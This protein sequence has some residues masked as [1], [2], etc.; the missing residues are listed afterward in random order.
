MRQAFYLLAIAYLVGA[1]LLFSDVM[2]DLR[3]QGFI[4]TAN[5]GKRSALCDVYNNEV[6]KNCRWQD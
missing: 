6:V 4:L 3:R 2:N 1:S 5:T